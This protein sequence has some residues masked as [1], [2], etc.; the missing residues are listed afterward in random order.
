MTYPVK[1]M[2]VRAPVKDAYDILDTSFEGRGRI[3]CTV[4]DEALA[5]KVTKSL[6]ESEGFEYEP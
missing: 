6:N 1:Y 3:I 4:Y 5:Y 2:P